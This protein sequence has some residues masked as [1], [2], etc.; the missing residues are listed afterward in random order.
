MNFFPM[1]ELKYLMNNF[2]IYQ[3]FYWLR[4]QNTKNIFVSL[5]D[6]QSELLD[7]IYKIPLSLFA[8]KLLIF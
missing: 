3:I 8:V 4:K 7:S 1:L 6:T 2:K 5:D